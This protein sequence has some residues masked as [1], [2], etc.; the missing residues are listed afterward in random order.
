MHSSPRGS[1]SARTTSSIP[2]VLGQFFAKH[3]RLLIKVLAGNGTLN[4]T[5]PSADQQ[6]RHAC[7]LA[8]SKL[9]CVYKAPSVIWLAMAACVM[10]R[11]ANTTSMAGWRVL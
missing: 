4:L 6:S 11:C 2:L 9:V 8:D 3:A 7:E 5:R 10:T 1:Q